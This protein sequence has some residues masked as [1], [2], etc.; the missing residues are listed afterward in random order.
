MNPNYHLYLAY[1]QNQYDE[2][3]ETYFPISQEELNEIKDNK[4]V[5]DSLIF[6][7]NRHTIYAKGKEFGGLNAVFQKVSTGEYDDNKTNILLENTYFVTSV[8]QDQYGQI[9]YTYSTAYVPIQFGNG[10]MINDRPGTYVTS[11]FMNALGE[12]TYTYAMVHH[13]TYKGTLSAS[14]YDVR[15]NATSEIIVDDPKRIVLGDNIAII[16]ETSRS[17]NVYDTTT[18]DMFLENINKNEIPDNIYSNKYNDIIFVD[19][20]LI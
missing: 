18:G 17:I 14:I 16:E 1:S 20:C 8:N 11:A 10:V 5:G 12:I 15:N 9:S 4:L 7:M 3:N 2:Q 19:M 13:T 6:D